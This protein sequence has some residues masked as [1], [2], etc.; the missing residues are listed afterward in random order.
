MSFKRQ[1]SRGGSFKQRNYGDGGAAEFRRAKNLEIQGLENQLKSYTDVHGKKIDGMRRAMATTEQMENTVRSREDQLYRDKASMIK[2]RRDDEVRSLQI[3]AHNAKIEGSKWE[4]LSPTL[5]KT[6][7][8]AGSMAAKRANALQTAKQTELDTPYYELTNIY[9][10]DLL[11]LDLEQKQK[12]FKNYAEYSTAAAQINLNKAAKYTVDAQS[13]HAKAITADLSNI[14]LK[15]KTFL[16]DNVQ[17]IDLDKNW[18]TVDQMYDDLFSQIQDAMGWEGSAAEG[19]IEFRQE[20]KKKQNAAVRA[21]KHGYE[22]DLS[23]K[24]VDKNYLA[25]TKSPSAANLNNAYFVYKESRTTKGGRVGE[26][27]GRTA[28]FTKIAENLELPD[29][30][31]AEVL[32]YETPKDGQL[33]EGETWGDRFPKLKEMMEKARVAA[34]KKANTTKNIE[35]KYADGED[36][37]DQQDWFHNEGEYA[38]GGK[39]EGQGYNGNKDDAVKRANIARN[40]GHTKT[41]TYIESMYWTS[42]AEYDVQFQKDELHRLYKAGNFN[43]LHNLLYNSPHLKDEVRNSLKAQYLPELKEW[44]ELGHDDTEVRDLVEAELRGSLGAERVQRMKTSDIVSLE[45][46]IDIGVQTIHRYYREEKEG[47]TAKEAW[48]LATKRFSEDVN[49]IHKEEGKVDVKGRGLFQLTPGSDAKNHLPYFT[50]QQPRSE[51]QNYSRSIVEL[52]TDLIS[53]PSA[54]AESYKEIDILTTDYRADIAAELHAGYAIEVPDIVYDISKKWKIP[55]HEIINSELEKG[56]GEGF[57]PLKTRMEPGYKD[58]ILSEIEN[59]PNYMSLAERVR[60]SRNYHE[61]QGLNNFEQSGGRPNNID[62]VVKA[63]VIETPNNAILYQALGNNPTS[64]ALGT[65]FN[66]CQG[67][68]FEDIGQIDNYGEIFTNLN[69]YTFTQAVTKGKQYGLNYNPYTQK[70]FHGGD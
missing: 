7:L 1:S 19:V 42:N 23:E 61:L 58:I 49:Y 69:S 28:L 31:I 40:K 43:E 33:K 18:K 15:Q 27:A 32:A 22:Y 59:N 16:E 65:V 44:A 24:L 55:V 45:E 60:S 17:G 52:R 35:L 38:A 63:Q 20:F 51:V 48:K 3:A 53:G 36:L 47:K 11:Q 30:I 50:H 39:F 26:E 62:P 21:A 66:T 8:D 14:I 25:F 67:C 37:K 64:F 6:I 68:S 5:S 46:T 10:K 34:K 70:L 41:A 54:T 4:K 13:H 9:T 56:L 57:A 29:S 12:E 2:D